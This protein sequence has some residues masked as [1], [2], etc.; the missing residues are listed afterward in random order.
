MPVVSWD[1]VGVE[2]F[3]SSGRFLETLGCEGQ[4]FLH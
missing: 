4:E 2:D 3:F 1:W